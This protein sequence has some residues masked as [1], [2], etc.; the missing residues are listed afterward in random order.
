MTIETMLRKNDQP[1]MGSVVLSGEYGLRDV[2]LG[3]PLT[4]GTQAWQEVIELTLTKKEK[5]A[6]AKSAEKVRSNYKK[7]LALLK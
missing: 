3:V 5:K 6:L 7:A 2:A 4:A 1:L